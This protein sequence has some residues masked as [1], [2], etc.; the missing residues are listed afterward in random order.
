MSEIAFEYML[1][2]LETAG[3][4]GTAV[5]PTHYLPLL[6]TLKPAQAYYRPNESTGL[7]AAATRQKRVREWGE[8]DGEGPL[9]VYNIGVLLSM[10]IQDTP[11]PTTPGGATTSRL[12]TY[13]PGMTSDDRRAATIYFGDP[14]Q[15]V[16]RGVYGVLDELTFGADAFSEDGATMNASGMTKFPTS[17]TPP[18]APARLAGPLISGL[19]MQMWLNPATSAI[20]TTE[21]TSTLANAEVTIPG[22]I[23]LKYYAAGP[24]ASKS[25]SAHGVGKRA[26]TLNFNLSAAGLGQWSNY[27]NDTLMAAR[28]RLNGPEIESGFYHYVE[29]DAYGYLAFDD[30]SEIADTNRGYQFSIESVYNA[31]AGHDFAV[32]V[33]NDRTTL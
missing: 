8:W 31:S 1:A 16:L 15:N 28:L 12:W 7:L 19:N 21:I 26:A 14:N 27:S 29:V 22:A 5:N 30:W 4:E 23:S 20:G 33:Q 32:K 2:G 11:T 17:I 9:D 6:G 24:A 25:Y 13:E 3:S 10:L 18:T